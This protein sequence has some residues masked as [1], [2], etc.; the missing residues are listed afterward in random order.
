MR[1]WMAALLFCIQWPVQAQLNIG[2]LPYN[3]P[4]E[5]MADQQHVFMGF[6]IDVMNE[7][8][9][10]L[11]VTCNF[12]PVIFANLLPAVNEGSIDL[13]MGSI[14]VTA[15]REQYVAFSIPYLISR[16]QFLTSIKA[17]QFKEV[18][19]L[20]GK[21][22]GILRGTIFKDVLWDI[23]QTHADLKTYDTIPNLI[24][25]LSNGEVDA[26]FLLHES[27]HYW[28]LQDA[29]LFKLVGEPILF[30]KGISMMT[31]QGNDSLIHQINNTI[32]DMEADGTYLKI[33]SNYFGS[34]RK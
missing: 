8:C 5:M 22:I 3:P 6:E 23:F 26:A 10:R 2:V 1:A 16:G 34:L 20:K 11:Q 25:G 33:Y 12:S 9:K 15:S 31:R 13:A 14:V 4:F 19:D 27:A 32:L 21:K 28:V 24:Q 29:N 7:I 17:D 18:D 30:G